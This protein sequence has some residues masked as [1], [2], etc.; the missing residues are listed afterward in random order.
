MAS[1]VRAD[2]EEPG[3][4]ARDAPAGVK[5]FSDEVCDIQV[6]LISIIND[7]KSRINKETGAQI[8]QYIA[9]LTSI[10]TKQEIENAA[11]R[12]RLAER[13]RVP[14]FA[15]VA[16]GEP[17]AA[18]APPPA[19]AAYVVGGAGG[20][21]VPAVP[22]ARQGHALLIY[23][24]NPTPT[25]SNDIKIMLKKYFEPQ[26]IGLGE[27]VMKEIRN[28][29]AI[30]SQSLASLQRLADAI[31]EHPHT[32]DAFVL[33]QPAKRRPQFRVSGVDPDIL[34]A[35]F[36]ATLRA[37]NPEVQLEPNE[38]FLRTSFKEKSGNSTFIF[39]VTP[40]GYKKL[41][42]KN[43]VNL[44]WTSCLIHENFY[45]PKCQKCAQYGHTKKYC[46]SES[47]MCPL[48]A[49][50]HTAGQCQITEGGAMRCRACAARRVD[51]RHAFGN[52][53]CGTLALLVARLK[54][55]TD[56]PL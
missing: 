48:C 50:T 29:V 4:P 19:P 28:G 38:F 26:R 31:E 41:E 45:V 33:R 55:R 25:P 10:S 39:D 20:G 36:L 53:S 2:E 52:V 54:G 15:E 27:V 1:P 17:V 22:P 23:L 56:Y 35:E 21:A 8:L 51:A 18:A 16:R 9:K 14:T 5:S 42:G 6:K 49:G 11:L 44:G 43:K 7:E 32:K 3:G 37:Q 40:E 13:E 46:E 24:A 30:Q 34:P 47:E 12:A